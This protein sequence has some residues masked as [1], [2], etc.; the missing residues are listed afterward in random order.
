MSAFEIN[1]HYWNKQYMLNKQI[2]FIENNVVQYLNKY[3]ILK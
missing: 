2:L 1:K 3:K